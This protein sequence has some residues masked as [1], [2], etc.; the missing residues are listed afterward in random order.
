MLEHALKYLEAGFSVIPIKPDFNEETQKF[1]KKP[2]THWKAYQTTLPT[3]DEVKSWWT[4]WPNAM[5]GI[6]TGEVSKLYVIDCDTA[7]AYEHIQ[8][9]LPDTFITPIATTPRGGKH[10]WV[11]CT[12]GCRLRTVSSVKP[13]IDTRGDGGYIVAPPSQNS[14]GQVYQWL[15]G[16]GFQDTAPQELPSTMVFSL[17]GGVWGGKDGSKCSIQQESYTTQDYNAYKILQDGNRDQDLF[18]IGMA[19]ADG[20]Y[21]RS[22]LVQVLKVLARNCN[23]PFPPDELEVKIKSVF[24]RISVK[25][26]NLMDEV[27]EWCLLQK[28]SFKTTDIRHEL[29]ITTKQEI[30]NLSVIVNRLQD[31]GIIEKFGDMRGAYR[32]K[33]ERDKLEM[34]FIEEDIPEFDVKLPFGLSRIVSIYPKNIII[35]AGSK[36]A[37]KTSMLLQ[38]AQANQDA[39]EVV[40]LNSEMGDEEWSIR[41]KKMGIYKKEDKKFRAFGVHK[42]FHDMMDGSKKIF[43]VDYLEIHDKFYEIAKPIRLIHEAIKDGICFIGVQK[44]QGDLM[45]RGGDFSM[46]KSRLYL[47]MDFLKDQRCTQ[48]TIVDA[49]S[50]KIPESPRGWYKRIKIIDGAY[51]EAIDKDWKF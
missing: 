3:V 32:T 39:H 13:G 37:G 20:K 45:A 49:K 19:L 10:L 40:Y 22:E 35:I 30:K 36:S 5:I 6:L 31:N 50:P 46:E 24:G 1:D 25:D 16:L 47:S 51:M 48:M 41:L 8:E 44:K 33:D 17:K 38:I 28:G 9:E 12:N 2:H 29:Q 7:E 27:R 11:R 26:R 15:E 14:H 43:M 21:R 4:K 34:R 42:N 23:P 18:N